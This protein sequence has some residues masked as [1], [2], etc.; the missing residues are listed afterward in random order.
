MLFSA[1]CL[2]RPWPHAVKE[3]TPISKCTFPNSHPL[4]PIW[5]EG[6]S[7]INQGTKPNTHQTSFLQS[8][9]LSITYLLPYQTLNESWRN[10]AKKTHVSSYSRH[11]PIQWWLSVH[12][13]EQVHP[14]TP[15]GP[16]LL[17]TCRTPLAFGAAGHRWGPQGE[18]N[19]D[20]ARPGQ[21][22]HHTHWCPGAS[23]LRESRKNPAGKEMA[24]SLA[25]WRGD[26]FLGVG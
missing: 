3:P 15:Q 8:R 5:V 6:G 9:A 18:Q 2:R 23:E 17:G 20:K 19:S 16:G 21:E 14:I 10:H 13:Q 22:Q 26:V 24:R 25:G 4:G 7:K 12:P 1:V 11:R